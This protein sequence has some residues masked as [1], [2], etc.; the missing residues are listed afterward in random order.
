MRVDRRQF[1]QDCTWERLKRRLAARAIIANIVF[2]DSASLL[3][4]ASTHSCLVELTCSRESR[5]TLAICA[6]IGGETARNG[7]D[8]KK[9]RVKKCVILAYS[10]RI[11]AN[12][13]TRAVYK[14]Y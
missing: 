12:I 3:T 4:I 9:S 11:L 8:L 1:A 2:G 14:K 5:P 13:F 10:L 7:R 6:R